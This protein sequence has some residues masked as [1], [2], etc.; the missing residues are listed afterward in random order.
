MTKG[1]DKKIAEGVLRWFRQVERMEDKG[2]GECMRRSPRDE[3]LTLMRY[4]SCGLPQLCEAHEG[5]KSVWPKLQLKG[6]KEETLFF[7]SFLN[8]VA[9]FMV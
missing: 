1:V 2:E 5:W 8:F 4:H 3:P 9:H 7:F 6:H